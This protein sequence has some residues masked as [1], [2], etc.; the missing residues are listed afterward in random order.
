[1]ETECER[2]VNEYEKHVKIEYE[3]NNGGVVITDGGDKGKKTVARH[4]M[5]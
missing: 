2:L 3:V 4:F 1:M 5:Q